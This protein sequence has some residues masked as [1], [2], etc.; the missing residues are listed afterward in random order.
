MPNLR[1]LEMVTIGDALYLK[2]GLDWRKVPIQ[3][4][5]RVSMM[6]RLIPNAASLKDCALVGSEALAG[7]SM[8]IYEY[9]PPALAGV[10]SAGPQKVWI[11]KVDGLPH[12]MMALRERTDTRMIFEGVKPPIP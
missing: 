2:Q 6:N 9:T 7:Q 8:Q 12:R 4:G 1:T 5:M 11:G 3:P 10:G